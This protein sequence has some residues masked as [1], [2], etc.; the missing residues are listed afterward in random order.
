MEETQPAGFTEW[1]VLYISHK[2]DGA[3]LRTILTCCG[4]RVEAVP[5]MELMISMIRQI[6]LDSVQTKADTYH[7]Y[8]DLVA[9]KRT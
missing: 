2:D 4:R 7:T 1:I 8:G 6:K 9:Q 5:F 3:L